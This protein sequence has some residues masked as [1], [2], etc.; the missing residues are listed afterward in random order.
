MLERLAVRDL[1]LIAGADVRFGPGLNVVTGETGAGKSL[2]VQAVDLLLGGRAD[3]D[4]VRDGAERAV[5]EGEWALSGSRAGRAGALLSGFGIEFDGQTLIVRREVEK[6]GKSRALVNQSAVTLA[7]LR[8][9]G[10]F[11]ADLHGQ[12]EHQSLLRSDAGLEVLD[13]LGEL[14]AEV[15]RYGEA[16]AAWREAAGEQARLAASL[17]TFTER[18]EW[19]EH[20]AR[21]LDQ[22]ELR[23]GEDETLAG[24]AA[25][26]A[27]ADR[28]RGL[29]GAAL[30]RLAEGDQPAVDGLAAAA[31][32]LEQAAALDPS[33]A[34]T[35]P[36]VEEARIAAGEA[37]RA[38]TDY[39]AG[40][41]ADPARL[42]ALEA[43]RD[44]LAHLTRKYHRDLAGLMAY[45][46]ELAAELL[47]GEDGAG[48]D[49]RARARVEEARAACRLHAEE[50]S[51]RRRAAAREW[52]RRISR[53]L[54]PL[55]FAQASLEFAVESRLPQDEAF[56]ARGLDEVEMRFGANPGESPRTLQRIA[57]GGELSRVMLGLKAALEAQDPVDLLLFDEVDSGIG[58]AVAHAVGERLRRLSRHRQIICVTHLPMI[59]ALASHH[60]RVTKRPAGG[61]TVAELDV[62]EGRERIDELARMLA[63]D[64]VTETTRRQAR[65]M[66][67]SEA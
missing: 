12:H 11:L 54:K 20:A 47:T 26:L 35:R 6:G 9:A 52:G 33:L 51:R 36:L 57:S 60:V 31:R 40:L 16:L 65:E 41:D 5:I 3:A 22:A 50:L 14:S 25:R 7:N 66:L 10:E 2:L 27:H 44:Q 61:R 29:I 21:E 38:L 56:R 13:R 18:R 30:E 59:A 8:R 15:A 32:A 24:E 28:L 62:V 1:A 55:G 64:Q 48:A 49:Q 46:A 63:G 53:E 43:R 45:R 37:A 67:A 34:E 17:A 58:G 19:L 39:A 4:A 42:E 23:A